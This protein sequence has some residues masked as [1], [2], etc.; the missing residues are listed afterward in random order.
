MRGRIDGKPVNGYIYPWAVADPKLHSV[1]GKYALGFD[2]DG[3]TEP[4]SF[5]DPMTHEK[6]VDNQL[7]RALGCIQQFRGTYEYRPT[8]W[9]FVWGSMKVTT[10]AWLFTVSGE[11]L[12]HD[13]PVT[14]TF[15]RA[16][17]HLSFGPAGT[18]T[19]D[20]T[21]RIDPDPRSHHEFR[22]EIRNG[23]LTVADPGKLVLLLDTLAFT[24]LRLDKFHL[25]L[26]PKPNGHLEGIIGGYQ[27]LK[28]VYFGIAL[29]G[30]AGEGMIIND[31]P[32][33]YYLLKRNADGGTDPSSGEHTSISAAYHI[34]AVP[35]FAIAPKGGSERSLAAR[36]Q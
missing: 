18:A 32:G 23:V 22:G 33:I 24:E 5:E 8:Y 1:A 31:T 27:P 9:D 6:G 26:N 35:V 34:D 14:V 21:Y 17:E 25:R 2:L 11:S 19:P 7:F 3:K 20:M 29:S 4:A 36:S 30:M 15:D 10:P 28:D 13:G 12:D 16:L